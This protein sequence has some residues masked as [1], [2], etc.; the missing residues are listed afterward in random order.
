MRKKLVVCGGG[1]S[2]HSL[3]PFLKDSVFDVSVYTSKP[4]KWNKT[5]EVEYQDVI[6]NV[7]NCFSGNIVC[8]SSK[9]KEIVPTADY[10]VLCMPVHKY[11]V[12]L[13]EIAPFIDKNKTVCI[14]TLYG[15]GGFN[16]M[17]D[18][19][20]K[21]Y[22]LTNIVTF[23]FGLLP[24]ICRTIEYGK[25]GV[26]YGCKAVNY[27]AVSPRHY[28]KKLNDEFFNQVCFKW[29]GKGETMQADNFLS[30]T[31]SVD[32]QIIHTSRCLGLYKVYGESWKSKEKVPMFYKD[33][34]EVSADL[35]R[36]LDA[37][38]SVIRNEIMRLYPKRKFTYMLDYL[39]L[40]RFSY[41]SQNTDIKESFVNSKTLTAIAS[42]AVLCDDGLW[43]IDKNHR[44]FMDDIYYGN[45]IAKWIAEQLN[46]ETPTI[47]EILYW[48]QNVRNER[49]IDHTNRLLVDG[50]DLMGRFKAGLPCYYGIEEIEELLD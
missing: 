16:W 12:A 26:N 48:A 23:A 34:D 20:K 7:L 32:N 49:I 46:V 17:V 15:Q 30:L 25:K 4:E 41:Q 8:A 50:Q 44:F 38:Y 6:G 14:G 31:L 33:Y 40:E 10:I 29:F 13:H 9:P 27:A 24:W 22:G 21:E 11:R 18:E 42:P 36:K 39:A 19:I 3:I 5:I 1:S 28:F 47:D 35:L 45:C 37:D 2:A 43:R